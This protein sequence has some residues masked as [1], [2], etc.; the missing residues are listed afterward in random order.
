MPHL[1]ASCAKNLG[2]YFKILATSPK[3]GAE[4][5]QSLSEVHELRPNGQRRE[6][7]CK[8]KTRRSYAVLGERGAVRPAVEAGPRLHPRSLDA[9][10]RVFAR[11]SVRSI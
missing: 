11:L 9:R 5:R 10:Y 6:G 3:E 8:R 1:K 4:Q 2:A 7:F